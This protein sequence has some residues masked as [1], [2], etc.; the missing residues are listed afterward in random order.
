MVLSKLLRATAIAAAVGTGL[1]GLQTAHAFDSFW[2]PAGSSNWNT[3]ANWIS[4][5]C[6]RPGSRK[7]AS[8]TTA[9]RQRSQPHPDHGRR[10]AGPGGRRLGTLTINTGGVFT[11][12]PVL[13]QRR[14]GRR[15]RRR[16]TL[17]CRGTARCRTRLNIGGLAGQPGELQRQRRREP[18]PAPAP[19]RGLRIT[20]PS[21]NFSSTGAESTFKA[22]ASSRRRSPP[23]GTRPSKPRGPPIWA[24]R[25]R[26]VHRRHARAGQLL[27]LFDAAAVDGISP[28]APSAAGRRHRRTGGRRLGSAYRL[29]SVAGGTNGQ[30]LQV[31]LESCWSCGSTA[32]RANSRS[33]IPWARP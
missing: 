9:A 31:G 18:S 28:T 10:H 30:L 14:G 32:T 33:A 26:E 8:S 19:S 1:M 15:R 23:P 2:V 16:G 12:S 4:G 22:T 13:H 21:V 27:Q 24:A 20:G 29:R 11:A 7:S 6:L 5:T 3:P 17:N 25:Q